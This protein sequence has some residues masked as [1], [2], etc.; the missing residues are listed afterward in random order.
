M[1]CMERN[2]RTIWCANYVGKEEI[3]TDG[4]RT[5]QFRALLESP[6]RMR[7]NVSAARG[8]S[9]EELFGIN[10]NYDKT[11]VF[12][13]PKIP[14]TESTVFWIDT[15]PELLDDGSTETAW[16]YVVT[17]IARSLNSTTVAIRKVTVQ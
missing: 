4:K 16:D 5:G 13:S 14:I 7:A 15:L 6:V 2:K 12:E 17:K 1:R 11:V 3:L 10:V 9:N 8:T